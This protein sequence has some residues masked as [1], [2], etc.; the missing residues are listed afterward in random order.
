MWN[1]RIQF[2][3]AL[4]YL[5]GIRR[6]LNLIGLFP[7]LFNISEQFRLCF[8]PCCVNRCHG[9]TASHRESHL[10]KALE[11]SSTFRSHFQLEKVMI[12]SC[13]N[14]KCR[15]FEFPNGQSKI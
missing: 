15:D 2:K 9:L 6:L 7:V 5:I 14:D 1:L 12:C 3:I 13:P 4:N 8:G 11:I 10:E